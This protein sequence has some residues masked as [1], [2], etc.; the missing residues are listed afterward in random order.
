MY[1]SRPA[2]ELNPCVV[3]Q[4]EGR[5][6]Q[7]CLPFTPFETQA[8]RLTRS[9]GHEWEEPSVS[10][11]ARDGYSPA[12]RDHRL[13]RVCEFRGARPK[14]LAV[15]AVGD[16]VIMAVTPLLAAPECLRTRLAQGGGFYCL[17]KTTAS[18]SPLREFYAFT[19]IGEDFCLYICY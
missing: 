13:G 14:R 6:H 19:D 16:A 5:C 9:S 3:Y 10:V 11:S 4:R 17:C 7:R 18:T 12:L 15:F 8:P 2:F 1:F